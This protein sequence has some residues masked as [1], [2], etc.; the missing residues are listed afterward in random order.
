MDFKDRTNKRKEDFLAF[1]KHGK[2]LFMK[3]HQ[4]Y[5]KTRCTESQKFDEAYEFNIIIPKDQNDENVFIAYY[6]TRISGKEPDARKNAD[7]EWEKFFHNNIEQGC[8]MIFVLRGQGLVDI[9][10]HPAM[11]DSQKAYHKED[12][13]VVGRRISPKKLLKKRC[14]KRYWKILFSYMEYTSL[15]GEPNLFDKIRYYWYINH[16]GYVYKDGKIENR[17]LVKNYTKLALYL[18]ATFISMLS[19]IIVACV[20]YKLG[21]N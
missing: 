9:I 11:D 16:K 12:C 14:I 6:G 18:I 8:I 1:Q 13:I 17:K 5:Q 7:G 19:A 4:R 15:L 21:M 2:C 10:I 20:I 3:Y